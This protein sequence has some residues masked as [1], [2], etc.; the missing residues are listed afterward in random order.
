MLKRLAINLAGRLV[1]L[2][3]IV[4]ITFFFLHLVPGSPF[5]SERKLPAEIEANLYQKYGLH[6]RSEYDFFTWVAKDTLS[7]LSKLSHLQMGPSLKYVDR[8]VADI[9]RQALPASF[10]LGA[11]SLFT[12]F[13]AALIASL[14]LVRCSNRVINAVY[15]FFSSVVIAMPTFIKAIILISLF[16]LWLGVL[17]AALWEGPLHMIL[18]VICLS[19][20][21]FFLMSQ[22]LIAEI[23]K[24]GAKQYVLS[25]RAKGLGENVILMKHVLKNSLNPLLAVTGS[26]ATGLLTGSFI[27]ETIFSIPGLGRHFVLAVIDRDYFLV[28]GITVVYAGMLSLL[29]W[30]ID[31]A[32]MKLDPR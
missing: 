22:L 1:T 32:L 19:L 3:V 14:G 5:D 13:M 20:A 8:D 18:P 25:A 15:A 7:Y 6:K 16:S 12:A 10:L 2:C 11:I 24:E 17:P 28:M 30:L 21:P 4:L 9:I 23:K 27:V 31:F 26:V 29:G